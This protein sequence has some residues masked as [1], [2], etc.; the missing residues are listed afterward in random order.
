MDF[1]GTSQNTFNSYFP[2]LINNMFS[3]KIL[4]FILFLRNC[5]AECGKKGWEEIENTIQK[6]IDDL[7]DAMGNY[8]TSFYNS[9]LF[10]Y[11]PKIGVMQIV[12][13]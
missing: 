9:T 6:C 3:F 5:D 2:L 11:Y 1:K 12:S 8:F 7:A 10:N 4:F 13:C